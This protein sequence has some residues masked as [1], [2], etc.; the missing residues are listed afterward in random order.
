MRAGYAHVRLCKDGTITLKKVHTIVAEAFLDYDPSQ[1]DRTDVNSLVVDHKNRNK[2]DNRLENLDVVTQL[3]NARRYAEC[4]ARGIPDQTIYIDRKYNRRSSE[5]GKA[6]I[7]TISLPED[8]VER[9]NSYITEK[10]ISRSKVI[11][12]AATKF[13][14]GEKTNV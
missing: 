14:D 10:K 6:K 3:E 1:Y 9:L 12:L 8:L 2:I 5:F 7:I 4:N 13:L 11:F